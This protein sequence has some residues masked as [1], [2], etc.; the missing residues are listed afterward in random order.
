MVICHRMKV[1]VRVG[2]VRVHYNMAARAHAEVWS[3]SCTMDS[4]LRGNDDA[5][6]SLWE[7]AGPS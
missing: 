6:I 7:Q 4:R 2:A 1:R 3:A 5:E